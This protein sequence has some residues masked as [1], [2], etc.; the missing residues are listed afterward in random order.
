MS[1]YYTGKWTRGNVR[2]QD[3]RYRRRGATLGRDPTPDPDGLPA[4]ILVEIEAAGS[5]R[6]LRNDGRDPG[7]DYFPKLGESTLCV[8]YWIV[9]G[10]LSLNCVRTTTW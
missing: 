2:L 3:V 4:P 8:T 10:R 7:N 1:Q 6:W 5:M 9:M